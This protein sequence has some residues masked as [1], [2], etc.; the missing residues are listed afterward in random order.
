MIDFVKSI[1][2]MRFHEV[3]R[4]PETRSKSMSQVDLEGYTV[5]KLGVKIF[6]RIFTELT[7]IF[8]RKNVKLNSEPNGTG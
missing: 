3:L 8:E 4:N 5:L 7:K 1:Q 2:L 6:F